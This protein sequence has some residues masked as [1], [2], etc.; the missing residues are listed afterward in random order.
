MTAARIL[1]VC[2][3]AAPAAH[4]GDPPKHPAPDA[5]ALKKAD[6]TIKELF[7]AD[8]VKFK[9]AERKVLVEKLMKVAGA[10]KDPVARFA[11][12]TEARDIHAQLGNFDGAIKIEHAIA[13]DYDVDETKELAEIIRAVFKVTNLSRSDLAILAKGELAKPTESKPA[14]ELAEAW[15]LYGGQEKNRVKSLMLGRAVHWY[16]IAGAGESGLAK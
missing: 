15:G 16:G 7:K 2:L 10:E 8:F 9:G 14:V 5:D 13:M 11:L 1:L 12:L 6:A 3:F 4:A